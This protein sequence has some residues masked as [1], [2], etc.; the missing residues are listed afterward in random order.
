M[1]G[2]ID[3]NREFKEGDL[4]ID[5]PRFAPKVL[6]AIQAVLAPIKA[7]SRDRGVTTEQLVLAWTLQQKGVSHVLVGTRDVNQ[8][9]ANAIAGSLELDGDELDIITQAAHAW[10]GFTT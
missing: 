9:K 1:T 7:L 4:R 10:P 5:N 6:N 2:R 8:A 3:A